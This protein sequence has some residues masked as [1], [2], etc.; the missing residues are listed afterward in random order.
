LHFTAG[1]C[2]SERA[3][4]KKPARSERL[5]ASFASFSL[6]KN[7]WI[8]VIVPSKTISHAR[9]RYCFCHSNIK[10]ISH[11]NRL[12]FSMH[13]AGLVHVWRRVQLLPS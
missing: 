12:I 8:Y 10:S 11:R 6:I 1:R 9:S 3:G 2:V 13:I 5:S 4:C 7:K